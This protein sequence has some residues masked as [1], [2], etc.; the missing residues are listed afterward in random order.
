MSWEQERINAVA[1]A[2]IAKTAELDGRPVHASET[3]ELC[4]MA[5]LAVAAHDALVAFDREHLKPTPAPAPAAEVSA[6]AASLGVQ[7][8]DVRIIYQEGWVWVGW[9]TRLLRVEFRM[10]LEGETIEMGAAPAR[11][12]GRALAVAAMAVEYSQGVGEARR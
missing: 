10:S 7:N 1:D 12:F 2:L 9:N 8:G 4:A 3:A 6:G 11:E 5:G